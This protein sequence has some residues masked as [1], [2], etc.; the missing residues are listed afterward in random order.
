[1]IC[2]NEDKGKFFL[3]RSSSHLTKFFQDCDTDYTHDGSTRNT[4]VANTLQ[5]ILS[6][7]QT[8]TATLPETFLLVIKVLMDKSDAVNE[9]IEEQEH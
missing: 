5:V 4:W 2:G 7:L 1:M 9:D 6:E 8:N 3:Y